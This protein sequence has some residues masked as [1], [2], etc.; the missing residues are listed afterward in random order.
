MMLTDKVLISFQLHTVIPDVHGIIQAA[1]KLILEL[2]ALIAQIQELVVSLTSDVKALLHKISGLTAEVIE[3][4]LKSAVSGLLG[5]INNGHSL[6]LTG[7]ALACLKV[8]QQSVTAL[9]HNGVQ[10]VLGCV[11]SIGHVGH[12]ILSEVTGYA[13][14][15]VSHSVSVGVPLIMKCATGALSLSTTTVQSC[16]DNVVH[17]MTHFVTTTLQRLK[18]LVGEVKHLVAAVDKCLGDATDVLVQAVK[19]VVHTYKSCLAGLGVHV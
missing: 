3:K 17:H 5:V 18:V 14:E 13:T 10:T 7:E 6:H 2:D 8:A 16:A 12:K 11:G 1:I 9:I 19:A 15:A 4:T